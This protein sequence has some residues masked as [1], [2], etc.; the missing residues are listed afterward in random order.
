MD[1]WMWIVIIVAAAAVAIALLVPLI[2]RGQRQ[3]ERETLQRDF[4]PEYDRAVGEFGSERDAE[5]ALKQRRDRVAKLKLRPLSADERTR[6]AEAWSAAQ[7]R[8]VDDPSGAVNDAQRCVDDAMKARGFPVGDFDRQAEDLSVEHPYVVEH[9]RAACEVARA[10]ERGEADTEQLR[11]AVVHYRALFTDLN[12]VAERP[13]APHRREERSGDRAREREGR[14]DRQSGG[15]RYGACGRPGAR[16]PRA[17]P[18]CL[19]PTMRR[20]RR[21]LM[22]ARPG[23]ILRLRSG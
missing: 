18:S 11:Q 12:N 2:M 23:E 20:W 7:S 17:R 6:F 16:T 21:D 19:V 15:V 3:R 22:P 4:G 5:S 13:E 14:R 10:N 8:F 9:Y 1:A